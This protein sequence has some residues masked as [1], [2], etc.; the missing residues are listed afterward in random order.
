MKS[1]LDLSLPQ[2]PR[3]RARPGLLGWLTFLASAA[4]LAL[5]V[6]ILL[7]ARQLG[8][9]GAA[10]ADPGEAERLKALATNLEKRTLYVQAADVWGE[11]MALAGLTPEE[12]AR[13]FYRRGKCLKEGGRH[14]EAARLLSEADTFPELPREEKQMA[15]QM[16]LECLAALGKEDARESVARSF[17]IR[18]EEKGTVLA[19][20]GS[21]TIPREE[22]RAE[23]QGAAEMM[24]KAGGAPLTPAETKLKAAEIAEKELKSPESAKRALSQA[25]SR[26]VLYREGIERG[27]GEDAATLEA[28]LK[29]RR[30]AI[31][32]R[33]IETEVENAMKSLGPTEIDNHYEAHKATFVEKAGAEAAFAKFPG[34][35][36]AEAAIGKLKDP[37]TA[38][39][40]PLERP[41]GFVVLG[42]P[43]PGIGPSAEI[44]AHVLQ[45]AEGEVSRRA[46]EHEGA[47]HVFRVEKKR[48]ERQLS[49]EEAEPLV[50]ADLAR[51]KQKEAVDD[52]RNLLSRKFHVEIVEEGLAGPAPGESPSAPEPPPA[53]SPG[54]QTPTPPSA[55][56]SP[57]GGTSTSSP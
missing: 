29:F 28:V 42:E 45:L 21:D 52:L 22:L 36:E 17:A 8:G 54:S 23:L 15:R 38:A 14:A 55:A 35:A 33:V 49:R 43:V 30:E 9:P 56:P 5:L 19:R 12:R 13:T 48:P 44:A 40:V 1:P 26:H 7:E 25:I 34:R 4:A 41:K 3:T 24:L 32:N 50:R 20:V 53:H 11:H 6:L 47:F 2:A 51:L 57:P 27:F 37:S 16:L 18:E 46:I 31:A 10:P 39:S